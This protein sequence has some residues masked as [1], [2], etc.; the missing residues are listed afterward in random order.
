MTGNLHV[1]EHEL[2]LEPFDGRQ[3]LGA[4]GALAHDLDVG[5]LL[6]QRQHALARHRLVVDD[7]GA[8]LGHGF[9]VLPW[10]RGLGAICSP[11]T[12]VIPH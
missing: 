6:Q 12:E 1:E 10:G 9:V 11:L 2:G 4:V 5:L 3:R 8:N 7:Q